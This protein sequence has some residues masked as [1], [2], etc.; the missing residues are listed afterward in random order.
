MVVVGDDGP[1]H[2]EDVLLVNKVGRPDVERTCGV[3][4]R[5]LFSSKQ[6]QRL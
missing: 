6:Y 1:D 5:V 4:P 2:P 3:K